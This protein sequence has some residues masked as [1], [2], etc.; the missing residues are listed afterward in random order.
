MSDFLDRLIQKTQN[1]ASLAQPLVVSRFAKPLAQGSAAIPEFMADGPKDVPPDTIVADQPL[2]RHA[3]RQKLG[4]PL[5]PDS[6]R[7]D[8]SW[9][10]FRPDLPKR[11][12]GGEESGLF[13]PREDRPSRPTEEGD[14]GQRL[15]T[16]AT[17]T[18]AG[19][20]GTP[21]FAEGASQPRQEGGA[22]VSLGP[23][24]P[25]PLLMPQDS[26]SDFRRPLAAAAH[27][28][29]DEENGRW[30]KG[31]G[32][33]SPALAGPSRE[34]SLYLPAGNED[35]PYRQ[36][37]RYRPDDLAMANQVEPPPVQ[38]TIGRVE[39]RAVLA[40]PPQPQA[41]PPRTSKLSLEDYLRQGREGKR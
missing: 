29:R 2:D 30:V 23:D 11:P 1:T 41:V 6:G 3:G 4:L 39:V 38:V 25:E 26:A 32:T 9:P 5:R 7:G 31:G 10:E 35:A 36:S 20:G 40:P 22:A 13:E 17:W 16:G 24:V 34:M 14:A 8:F 27:C 15:L 21:L 33:D 12:V 19:P 28:A 18:G 37:S